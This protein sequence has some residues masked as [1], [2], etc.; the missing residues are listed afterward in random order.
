MR[1]KYGAPVS[2]ALVVYMKHLELNDSDYWKQSGVISFHTGATTRRP[3]QEDP[4]LESIS[5]YLPRIFE[6]KNS[7]KPRIPSS[8][9]CE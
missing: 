4:S 7:R 1:L 6:K 3:N 5:E 9:A 2:H 8:A